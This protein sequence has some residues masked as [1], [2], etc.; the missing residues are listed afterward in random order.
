M[1][2]VA[3]RTATLCLLLLVLGA[4]VLEVR[5]AREDELLTRI[6]ERT[7]RDEMNPSERALALTHAVHRTLGAV[8]ASRGAR[9]PDHSGLFGGNLEYLLGE[10]GACGTHSMLLTRL[11]QLA[12]IDA[13]IAQMRVDGVWGGHIVSLAHLGDVRTPLDALF[14]VHFLDSAGRPADIE[15][16]VENW[17]AFASQPP[18]SYPAKYDYDA[19]RLTNWNRIPVVLPLVRKLSALALGEEAVDAFSL[20]AHVLNQYRVAARALESVAIVLAA[21]LLLSLRK[22]LRSQ[23]TSRSEAAPDA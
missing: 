18:P 17:P 7:I 10:G 23:A 15:S 11:L 4:A 13:S 14:D 22:S 5:A 8:N 16:V 2:P 19:V 1:S 9:P 20:R 21:L 3:V 6:V 12:G